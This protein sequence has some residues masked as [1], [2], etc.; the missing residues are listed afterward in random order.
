MDRVAGQV[1]LQVF[2]QFQRAGIAATRFFGEAF[3]ADRLQVARRLGLPL[4]GRNGRLLR[5]ELHRIQGIVGQE[6]RTPGEALVEHGPQGIDIDRR[7]LRLRQ[8]KHLLG[9]HVARRAGDPVGLRAVGRV[10]EMPGQAKIA[11]LRR[12]VG[13]Q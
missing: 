9:G 1:S 2:G 11:D 3:Q 4:P 6:G 7:A 12:A 8:A 13:R 10:L 5:D